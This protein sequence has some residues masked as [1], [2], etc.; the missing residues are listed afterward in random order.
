M[1]SSV[2][3]FSLGRWFEMRAAFQLFWR[4]EALRFAPLLAVVK[5]VENGWPPLSVS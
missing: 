4:R 1:I 3:A 2:L 5:S